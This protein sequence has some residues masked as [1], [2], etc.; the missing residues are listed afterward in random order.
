MTRRDNRYEIQPDADRLR[1]YES[2]IW[3][4]YPGNTD[5]KIKSVCRPWIRAAMCRG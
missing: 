5:P 4:S 3:C 1:R 2:V